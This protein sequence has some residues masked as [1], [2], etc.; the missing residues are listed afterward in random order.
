MARIETKSVADSPKPKNGGG[1]YDF[2][3]GITCGPDKWY[4][5]VVIKADVVPGK[6]SGKPQLKVFIGIDGDQ[7]GVLVSYYV[8]EPV[9]ASP[10]RL[11]FF[12]ALGMIS[13]HNDGTGF[14]TDEIV[15]L[16]L[17]VKPRFKKGNDGYADGHEAG[18]MKP[19]ISDTEPSRRFKKEPPPDETEPDAETDA[20]A[21]V[22]GDIPFSVEG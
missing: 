15:G 6:S 1:D 2:H 11:R 16:E 18:D 10:Q 3:R 21:E 14:D 22:T 5:A 19:I 9:N 4:R 13:V 8:V 17:L 7:G 20:G 12:R